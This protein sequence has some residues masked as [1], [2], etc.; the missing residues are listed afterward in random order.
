MKEINVKDLTINAMTAIANDWMLITA[1]CEERGYN[2]MTASWGHLGS[3]WGAYTSVAYVRPQRYTKEFV[4]RED[5]Y[6]LCFFPGYKKEL[7]Y[8]GSHSGRDEDKVAKMGLTPVFGEGYT[9][10]QEASLV[11]VCRKLYRAPLVEEGFIDKAVM[12]QCYPEKD[13]HD[14]YVGEIVKVLAAE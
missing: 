14:L 7:A 12:N 11:L 2:T 5:L 9:Y 10:F 13:F 3:L 8:L 6:T 1:G 4:D